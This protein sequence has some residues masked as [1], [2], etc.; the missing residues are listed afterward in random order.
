[1]LSTDLKLT[2]KNKIKKHNMAQ[3]VELLIFLECQM[4]EGKPH[5]CW[6]NY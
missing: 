6:Q 3:S 4:K 2:Q 5:E 1:M